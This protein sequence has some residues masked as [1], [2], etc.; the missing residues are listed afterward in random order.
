MKVLID[1]PPGLSK[2]LDGSDQT[3]K[4]LM[5]LLIHEILSTAEFEEKVMDQMHVMKSLIEEEE[6]D[7]VLHQIFK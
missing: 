2:I 5:I 6:Q 7:M 3:S 4:Q 1:V